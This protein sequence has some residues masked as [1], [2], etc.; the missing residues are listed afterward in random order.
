MAYQ[1]RLPCFICNNRFPIGRLSRI[2]GD[3]DLDFREIAI[4]RRDAR[5][6]PAIEITDQ[7]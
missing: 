7:T 6:L 2:D 4:T 1:N 5:E 3:E